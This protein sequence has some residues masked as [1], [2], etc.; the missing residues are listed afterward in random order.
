MPRNLNI[1]TQI[2]LHVKAIRA[3]SNR[4]K[5][6]LRSIMKLSAH[7]PHDAH[8]MKAYAADA[9]DEEIPTSS[10][11]ESDAPAQLYAHYFKAPINFMIV[12]SDMQPVGE[13]IEVTGKIEANQIAKEMNAIPWNF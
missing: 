2:S 1:N 9:L 4:Y 6:A 8:V 5:L 3:T 13:R 7:H 11:D 12:G 10:P